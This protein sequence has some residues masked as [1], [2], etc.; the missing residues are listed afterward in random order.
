VRDRGFAWKSAECVGSRGYASWRVWCRTV[1]ARGPAQLS[2]G[3]AGPD[4]AEFPDWTLV[5]RLVD[6][7]RSFEGPEDGE[8]SFKLSVQDHRGDYEARDLEALR[9]EFEERDSPE[10][11]AIVI[12]VN[13]SWAGRWLYWYQ[14]A[15][16]PDGYSYVT[17]EGTDEITVNG[18]AARISELFERAAKPKPEPSREPGVSGVGTEPETMEPQREGFLERSHGWPTYVGL[19]IGSASLLVAIIAIFATQ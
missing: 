1:R 15:V 17:L 3:A 13:G 12:R 14:V 7:L 4:P 11:R 16:R 8:G 2:Q 6:L 10:V 19:A 5:S 18:V 9:R